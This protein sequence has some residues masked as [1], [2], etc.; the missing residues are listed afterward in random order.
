MIKS[1]LWCFRYSKFFL[2][3]EIQ[4][5]LPRI[6]ALE[7]PYFY[8]RSCCF[9]KFDMKLIIL[10]FSIIGTQSARVRE[11]D[12]FGGQLQA[13][14]NDVDDL[15]SLSNF[16]LPSDFAE[17]LLM[18]INGIRLCH[19]AISTGPNVNKACF[20]DDDFQN[21]R[22][23]GR[24]SGRRARKSKNRKFKYREGKR[25]NGKRRRNRHQ[26]QSQKS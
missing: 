1:F 23:F 8:L 6:G 21:Y 20:D 18:E 12:P 19:N 7:L 4:R 26:M 5:V 16:E 2:T 3:K 13:I 11:P 10:L 15:S 17:Q 24:N 9:C 22:K 25:K 14:D